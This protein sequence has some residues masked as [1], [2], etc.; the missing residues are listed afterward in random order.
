MWG[1]RPLL[2]WG[3]GA[4]AGCAMGAA[5]SGTLLMLVAFRVAQGLTLAAI[6]V[7]ARASVRDMYSVEQGPRVMA[8]GLSGVGA[9]AVLAPLVGA[10]AVAMWG[11]RASLV[12]VAAYG[13]A[14][15]VVCVLWFKETRPQTSKGS[16]I[17][18][19]MHM[20]LKSRSFWGWTVLSGSSYSG[21]LCF[22]VCS[23]AIYIHGL[24]M[25]PAEYGWVP[26]SAS[27]VYFC[28]VLVCRH[29]LRLTNPLTLVRVAAVLSLVGG[30]IQMMGAL[31]FPHSWWCLL[32]GQWIF[33]MGHGVHQPCGQAGSV[34]D[35]PRHA[36]QAVAWSGFVM[37]ALAFVISQLASAYLTSL[38]PLE[39]LHGS[40]AWPLVIS[41]VLA[42]VSLNFI[43]TRGL[44][45]VVVPVS[46]GSI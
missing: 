35:F 46:S 4:Y 8:A 26:A 20:L 25:S 6:I 5:F 14:A 37:M 11:W 10:Y 38:G 42:G 15:L 28:S 13:A 40:P 33:A 22:L 2:L 7:C 41:T 3:L 43:A 12:V 30:C 32:L 27:A 18:L 45:A 29:F 34:A 24:G 31:L 17:T 23:P 44:Q 19:P 1:R 36:G 9:A 16:K 39:L 21:V